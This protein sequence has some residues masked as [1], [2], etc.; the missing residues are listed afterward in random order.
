MKEKSIR[1]V[2][3]GR[4]QGVWFR[5]W[6][7]QEASILNLDGWV[8]NRTDGTLEALFSGAGSDVDAMILACHQGPSS[9]RVDSVS[10]HPAP[11]PEERGFRSLPT[12]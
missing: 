3:E 10:Q 7:M 1:V 2:V 12:M 9:A 5:G 8:R 6:V 4:V 11:P